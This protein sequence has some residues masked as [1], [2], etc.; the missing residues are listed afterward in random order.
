MWEDFRH[1]AQ[2][3]QQMLCDKQAAAADRDAERAELGRVQEL[4][5]QQKQLQEAYA[6]QQ[7]ALLG[8]QQQQQQQQPYHAMQVSP[9]QSDMLDCLDAFVV[10]T[11]MVST[12]QHCT[13]SFTL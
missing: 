10:E 6:I 1:Q 9:R 7:Q 13:P 4:L 3:L 12:A 8:L 11:Q 2:D 5:Q